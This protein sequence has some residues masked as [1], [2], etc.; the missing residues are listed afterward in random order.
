MSKTPFE[1][2]YDLLLLAQSILDRKIDIINQQRQQNQ[3]LVVIELAMAP[4]TEDI[5]Q[6]AEK[7]NKFVS[8]DPKA[9]IDLSR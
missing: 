7:L 9:H 3:K 4:A 8:G 6:E 1:L 2:R 5:I